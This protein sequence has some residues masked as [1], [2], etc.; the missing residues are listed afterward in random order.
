MIL[1]TEA[2]LEILGPTCRN[3]SMRWLR[4]E[5]ILIFPSRPDCVPPCWAGGIGLLP[6]KAPANVGCVQGPGQSEGQGDEAREKHGRASLKNIP[7]S[8][9]PSSPQN[10]HP[11]KIFT[12]TPI[13]KLWREHFRYYDEL[14]WLLRGLCFLSPEIDPLMITWTPACCRTWPGRPFSGGTVGSTWIL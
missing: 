8:K 11:G 6:G 5:Y 7:S 1:V 14:C 2:S 9:T 10:F 4:Q 3:S 12:G 13:E